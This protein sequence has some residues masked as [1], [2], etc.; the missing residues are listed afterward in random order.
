MIRSDSNSR[1]TIIRLG[2]EASHH[3]FYHLGR[4]ETFVLFSH[5]RPCVLLTQFTLYDK[6]VGGHRDSCE[7]DHTDSPNVGFRRYYAFVGIEYF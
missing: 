2:A 5:L 1:W 4:V 6:I 3:Y 7:N